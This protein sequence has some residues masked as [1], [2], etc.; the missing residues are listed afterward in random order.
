[1]ALHDELYSWIRDA[2][3]ENTDQVKED[4][5][6]F[7]GYT[8]DGGSG[9]AV[10]GETDWVPNT[11]FDAVRNKATEPITRALSSRAVEFNRTIYTDKAI[12]EQ[13]TNIVH[14]C[15][16]DATNDFEVLTDIVVSA[17]LFPNAYGK[18]VLAPAPVD[19]RVYNFVIT[20]DQLELFSSIYDIVS[21]EA[22]DEEMT[23][24]QVSGVVRY[25]DEPVRIRVESLKPYDLVIDPE[26]DSASLENVPRIAQIGYGPYH[27]MLQYGFSE[28]DLEGV[29]L[30]VEGYFFENSNKELRNRIRGGSYVEN[31]ISS[32]ED[33]YEFAEY[34]ELNPDG[35]YHHVLTVG[36]KVLADRDVTTH[37]YFNA[38]AF[39]EPNDY[40]GTSLAQSMM[41]DYLLE[42]ELGRAVINKTRAMVTGKLIV[43]HD[44]VGG[45]VQFF[46][47]LVNDKLSSVIPI[48][49]AQGQPLGNAVQDISGARSGGIQELMAIFNG[50]TARSDQRVQGTRNSDPS[51]AA[52]QSA[53][54]QLISHEE[55]SAQISH[56]IKNFISHTVKPIYSKVH[57]LLKELP[58]LAQPFGSDPGKIVDTNLW[59][60]GERLRLSEGALHQTSFQSANYYA[61]LLQLLLMLHQAQLIE[62]P[63][64]NAVITKHI[65]TSGLGNP[66]DFVV[67]L[68]SE[69]YIQNKQA[70]EQQAQEQQQQEAQMAEAEA[71]KAEMI[72]QLDI[73]DRRLEQA[74]KRQDM[75]I[76]ALVKK[77]EALE[78]QAKVNKLIQEMRQSAEEHGLDIDL[79]EVELTC[80][81]IETLVKS[82]ETG[83][84]IEEAFN[85]ISNPAVPVVI[86]GGAGDGS[87]I[88]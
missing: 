82:M 7:Y 3:A 22:M 55:S 35:T 49:L 11:I 87:P 17:L 47:R 8:K 70:Q 29:S 77:Q 34:Y 52:G 41:S 13:E 19:Q 56:L 5:G 27:K 26:H 71:Q 45:D 18:V 65:S 54:G 24:I 15:V 38:C 2:R 68:N 80:K 9:D 76:N 67:D 60:D 88:A 64:I 75:Q 66:K 59:S 48:K 36:D 84:Q 30:G 78:A 6:A 37:P 43:D 23:Q 51:L 53:T 58:Y 86:A 42:K 32:F 10:D 14:E 33:V 39:S 63:G 83:V 73:E 81:E 79:K 74:R 46:N 20:H 28:E 16:K 69:E 1:M 12:S 72:F 40:V 31:T 61:Q 50:M 62:D 85:N 25:D 4:L 44:A 57:I 21:Y